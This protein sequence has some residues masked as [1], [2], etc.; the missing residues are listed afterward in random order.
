MKSIGLFSKVKAKEKVYLLLK[1]DLHTRFL[2]VWIGLVK[3]EREKKHGHKKER[4]IY[5]T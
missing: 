3:C 1:K 2:R 5:N 4:G